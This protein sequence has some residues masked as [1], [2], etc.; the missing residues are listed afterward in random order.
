MRIL[1]VLPYRVY[2]HVSG[3]TVSIRG[4]CPW[5]SKD[6]ERFWTLE[7]RGWTWECDDGTYGLCR[8]PA[9]TYAE[10]LET[11]ERVNNLNAF[12]KV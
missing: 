4:A 6:E 2:V 10:A 1:R 9:K 11:M 7:T 3:R 5:N 12:G 8:V